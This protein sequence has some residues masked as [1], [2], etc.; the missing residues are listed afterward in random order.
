MKICFI[1]FFCV[2]VVL[3]TFDLLTFGLSSAYYKVMLIVVLL[4][5]FICV[6]A[7]QT[8]KAYLINQIYQ[9]MI[10]SMLKNLSHIYCSHYIIKFIGFMPIYYVINLDIVLSY[11]VFSYLYLRSID[12]LQI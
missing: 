1:L 2:V 12:L 11:I 6:G 10:V 8:G 9:I 7:V 3:S 4:R 5:R